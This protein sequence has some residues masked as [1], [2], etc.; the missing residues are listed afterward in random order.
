MKVF[1]YSAIKQQ[2]CDSDILGLIAAIYKKAG[3]Q[4]LYLKL[5]LD[6]RNKLVE[7]AK[8]QSTEASNAIEDIDTSARISRREE[9][10][11]AQVMVNN[12]CEMQEY[13]DGKTK[14]EKKYVQFY[15]TASE[16]T[17]TAAK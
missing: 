11:R 2:K 17:Y 7:I 14:G 3:K 8:N 6:E 15:A 9:W 12:A 10:M 4:G 5:R 16:H 13:V 1:N